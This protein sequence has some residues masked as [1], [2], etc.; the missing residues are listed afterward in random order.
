MLSKED[1][2]QELRR[3]E[4]ARKSPDPQ[5][6]T[7]QEYLDLCSKMSYYNAAEGEAYYTETALRNRVNFEYRKKLQEC[8]ALGIDHEALIK[9]RNFLL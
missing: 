6:R 7:S 5:V 4:E 9:G 1:I 8:V 3:A 2:Q